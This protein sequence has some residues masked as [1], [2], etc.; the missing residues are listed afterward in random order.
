MSL[1]SAKEYVGVNLFQDKTRVVGNKNNREE[2]EQWGK[3]DVVHI[4]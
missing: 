2:T 1:A 3:E 4:N